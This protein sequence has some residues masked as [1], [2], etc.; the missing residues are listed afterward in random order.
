MLQKTQ[1]NEVR[2]TKYLVCVEN[3]GLELRFILNFVIVLECNFLHF[4]L[5]LLQLL[6]SPRLGGALHLAGRHNQVADLPAQDGR[7]APGADGGRPHGRAHDLRHHRPPLLHRHPRPVP[8]HHQRVLP[9][10][11]RQVPRG[12]RALLTGRL[13]PILKIP[14]CFSRV[15]ATLICVLVHRQVSCMEDLC[16]LL[17]FRDRSVPDQFYRMWTPLFLHA[18]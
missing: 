4:S 17:P 13:L 18:G 7:G 16:G 10:R 12:G 2:L 3:E 15:Q 9:L 11:R 8:D 6:R 14:P 1:Y 5:F